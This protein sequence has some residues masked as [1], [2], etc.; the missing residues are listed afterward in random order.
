MRAP[1]NDAAGGPPGAPAWGRPDTRVA[2]GLFAGLFALYVITGFAGIRSPDSEVAFETCEALAHGRGFALGPASTLRDFGHA[3]GVDGREYS[4]FGPAQPLVCAP[5]LAAVD[6]LLGEGSPPARLSPN[7]SF[8]TGDGLRRFALRQGSAGPEYREHV[9][10]ALVAAAFN[11]LLTALGAALF[12]ALCRRFAGRSA[13]AAAAL[14]YGT[15]SLAWPY[16]GTFFSEPLATLFVLGALLAAAWARGPGGFAASG[17]LAGLAVT[18]HVSTATFL[19]FVPWMAIGGTPRS[20]PSMP[21]ARDAGAPSAL[22]ASLRRLARERWLPYALGAGAV[23]LALGAFHQG[24]WGDPFET[25]RWADPER[26]RAFAHGTAVAPG[27]GLYGLLFGAGKGVFLYCPVVLLGLLGFRALAHRDRA[28]AW[29][30]GAA[31]VAR[32]VFV[33]TRSD[34]HGGYSL[35]PRLLVEAIPWLLVPLAPWLDDLVRAGRR[36]AAGAVLAAGWLAAVQQACFVVRDP[37]TA[38]HTVAQLARMQGFEPT[39]RDM[40]L[41]WSFAP[42]L[43]W[44]S[45]RR[46]PWLLQG[47]GVPD[48][49]LVAGLAALLALVYLLA[50]RALLARAAAPARGSLR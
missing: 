16:A 9:R 50:G 14:V 42:L 32:L 41:D 4:I 5:L 22:R 31:V 7:P 29:A 25:G 18:A 6:A 2:A 13:S 15:A 35:G 10:R 39:V 47:W 38:M 17:T 1:T 33:A 36:A 49:V 44:D 37:F 12:F 24:H 20:T 43:R 3:R 34:W 21:A 26:A 19:P 30:L 48:G 45:T 28:F 8:Y 11:P 46:A 23:L 40:Y 27:Q